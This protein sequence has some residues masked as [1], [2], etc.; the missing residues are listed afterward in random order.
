M[1]TR[2]FVPIVAPAAAFLIGLPLVA[3]GYKDGPA[4]A[5]TG[6]FGEPSCR[7]RHFDQPLNDPGGTLRLTGV[8][9]RYEPGRAY[10]ITI[11]IAREGM[12]RAGFEI[13]A[14]FASGERNS[15][16][17]GIWGAPDAR[18]Q[19]VES[20][21]GP[22]VLFA[23]QTDEGSTAPTAGTISWTLEWIAPASGTDPV[24]FNVAGNAANDDA[25]PLGD[26]VSV[27]EVHSLPE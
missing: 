5:V 14:R 8:P 7:H 24:Q 21:T 6:G 26:Y 23:R 19:I 9:R 25:S 13:A 11:A 1:A 10:P 18:E 22:P 3:S 16:Q 12:R 4:P 20:E 27:E 15:R 17:S 2:S